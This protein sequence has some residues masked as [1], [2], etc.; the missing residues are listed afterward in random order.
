ML[1]SL[2]DFWFSL[3]LLF[4]LTYLQDLCFYILDTNPYMTFFIFV[5]FLVWLNQT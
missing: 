3:V 5:L 2:Q 4:V 1:V